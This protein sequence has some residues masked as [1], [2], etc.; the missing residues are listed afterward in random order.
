MEFK[1]WLFLK[2]FI[3]EDYIPELSRESIASYSGEY[4]SYRQ[5]L[6]DNT[7]VLLRGCHA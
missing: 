5:S 3:T 6:I 4:N 2:Y 7:A 1:E